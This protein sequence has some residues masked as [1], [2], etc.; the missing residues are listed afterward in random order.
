MLNVKIRMPKGASYI[1]N[2]LNKNGFEAYIVGGCVRDSLLGMV[3]HDWDITTSATPQQVKEI[4]RKTVDTGIQHGTVTVLVD[5][6]HSGKGEYAYEVTTY[7]VDGIYEDHRRPKEVSFSKS[8]TEDLKRRDFTINAMA[9]NDKDGIVDIFGGSND[10]EKHII[11]CVGM[12][13]ERFDEDALRILRAVRFAAQLGF[14]IDE[15]TML[16]MKNQAAYLKDISAERIRE[17][18]TKL[19]TSDNPDMIK[20]AYE[21]GL[22]KV[23]L[24]EFDL[25]MDTPQNNPNHLYSVGEH[26]ICVMENVPKNVVLRYAALLH[27][28]GK[29]GCRITDE[30]GTDHFYGHQDKGSKIANDILRRLKFDNE[31]IDKVTKLVMY[32]DYGISGDVGIKAFRRFLTKLGVEN[33]DDFIII[34]NA[35]RLGQS[36]YNQDKKKENITRLKTMYDEIIDGKQCLA[37]KDLKIDGKDLIEL[38]MNPGRELGGVLKSLLEYVLDEPEL[39]DRDKLLELAKNM[40][41]EQKNF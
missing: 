14:D 37:I 9:Y 16:A 40:I 39:N 3:P 7:R 6:A 22:T 8:L 23:F 25:M 27:D 2:E 1:I 29:P 30:N 38:G 13:S 41:E 20:T 21:L 32:H 36:D 19:I 24:P 31:T 18:F 4:F 28:V 35:D 5:K 11:R 15:P 26:T 12:P 34:R 33:F 10:L 17:E